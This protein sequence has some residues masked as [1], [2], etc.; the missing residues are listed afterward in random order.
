MKL[1]LHGSLAIYQQIP[2][3]NSLT[4]NIYF[5]FDVQYNKRTSDKLVYLHAN[6]KNALENTAKNNTIFLILIIIKSVVFTKTESKL[7]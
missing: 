3:Y 1:Y 4:F 6:Y 5:I 7:H 2:K